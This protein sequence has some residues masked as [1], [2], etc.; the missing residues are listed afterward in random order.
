MLLYFVFFSSEK[1]CDLF[2]LALDWDEIKCHINKSMYGKFLQFLRTSDTKCARKLRSKDLC[3][4]LQ[5]NA[6]LTHKIVLIIITQPIPLIIEI[7]TITN[8]TYFYGTK[9]YILNK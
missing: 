6:A 7:N 8:H 2:L 9:T 4:F 3:S 5:F 1:N